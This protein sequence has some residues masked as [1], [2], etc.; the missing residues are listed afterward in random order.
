LGHKKGQKQIEK[1]GDKLPKLTGG[2]RAGERF[3]TI[4]QFFTFISTRWLAID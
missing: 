1:F 2:K 4:F 3:F